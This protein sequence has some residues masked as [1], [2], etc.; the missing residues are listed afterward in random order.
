MIKEK[1]WILKVFL[2]NEG[3]PVTSGDNGANFTCLVANPAI[4]VMKVYGSLFLTLNPDM[5]VMKVYKSILVFVSYLISPTF[6]LSREGISVASSTSTSSVSSLLCDFSKK[7]I[8]W[9]KSC[10]PSWV[11]KHTGQVWGGW[12]R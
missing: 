2:I 9:F 6:L 12:R 4:Q 7:T 11:W 3:L 5:Q 1:Y 10:R 8:D